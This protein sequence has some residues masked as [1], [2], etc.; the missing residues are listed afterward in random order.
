MIPQQNIIQ[1][2]ANM[3][4]KFQHLF[5]KVWRLFK[6][7]EEIKQMVTLLSINRLIKLPSSRLHPGLAP[8][9][10]P[11]LSH[12]LGPSGNAKNPLLSTPSTELL[13][14]PSLTQARIEC[15]L[16]LS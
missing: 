6:K 10:K 11:E 5:T 15:S 13:R 4:R 1:V 16:T 14:M 3:S 9:P 2:P 7:K 8:P 12:Q